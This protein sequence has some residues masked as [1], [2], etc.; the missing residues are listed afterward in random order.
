MSYARFPL[1]YEHD[2]CPSVC[3]SFW[4]FGARESENWQIGRRLVY[5]HVKVDPDRSILWWW[6]LLR[7]T[8]AC[9]KKKCKVLN[10]GGNM[11]RRFACRAISATAGL[12]VHLLMQDGENLLPV[13]FNDD[14][15]S[16]NAEWALVKIHW[17][18][19]VALFAAQFS[20]LRFIYYLLTKFYCIY[21]TLC[22]RL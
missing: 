14:R 1:C 2:V 16:R 8:S 11:S 6:I 7:K 10:F 20:F 3:L 22:S 4:H 18:H 12:L 21:S 15:H 9:G 13:G 19:D 5:L 17:G